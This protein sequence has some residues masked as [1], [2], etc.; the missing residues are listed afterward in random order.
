MTDKKP[1]K[2]EL[3]RA[4]KAGKL[5]VII[6]TP[7]AKTMKAVKEDAALATKGDDFDNFCERHRVNSIAGSGTS[8]RRRRLRDA[9]VLPPREA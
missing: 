9:T 2:A 1:T 5:R 3:R 4:G 6:A 8:P 7:D